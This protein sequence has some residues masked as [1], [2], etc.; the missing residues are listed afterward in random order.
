MEEI[1]LEEMLETLTECVLNKKEY[2]KFYYKDGK[3][4]YKLITEVDYFNRIKTE[5]DDFTEFEWELEESHLYKL[6]EQ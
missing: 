1:T 5:D 2:P 4:N 6:E 3:E